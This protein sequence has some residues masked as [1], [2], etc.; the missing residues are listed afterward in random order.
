[1][2]MW[3][4]MWTWT[5]TEEITAMVKAT[6]MGKWTRTRTMPT[7]RRYLKRLL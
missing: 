5:W 1:M 4:W 3:M 7:R 6:K 2:R